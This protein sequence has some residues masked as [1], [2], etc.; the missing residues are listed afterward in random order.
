M[1][2]FNGYGRRILKT[3]N[4]E[5]GKIEYRLSGQWV[6]H[7]Y[8]FEWGTQKQRKIAS[9]GNK[10]LGISTKI[11]WNKSGYAGDLVDFK[12][13]KTLVYTK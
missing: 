13:A 12:M 9:C 8:G 2:T 6:G 1:K 7:K 11:L 4:H 5:T 10:I 3:K